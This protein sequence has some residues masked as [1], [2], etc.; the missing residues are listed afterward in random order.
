MISGNHKK[1]ITLLIKSLVTVL[2]LYYIFDQLFLKGK[3]E[4]LWKQFLLV[5]KDSN[6]IYIFGTFFLM[7]LNWAVESAKWQY[8]LRLIEPANFLKSFKAVIAGV[9]ISIFTP[10]RIGEFGGR[11]LF[12]NDNHR[13]KAILLSI[14]GSIS[15]LLITVICGIIGYTIF[16]YGKYQFSLIEKSLLLSIGV[17][18]TCVSLYSYYNFPYLSNV[19]LRLQIL[20]RTRTYL[21]VFHLLSNR[22]LTNL[23]GLSIL[24]YLIFSIQ[25]LILLRVFGI[26]VHPIYGLV[27][28][29]IIFFV[30]A[31]VPT[32]ALTELGVRGAAAMFF[33]S[34]FSNNS[35]GILAASYSLWFINL[36]IPALLGLPFIIQAK[37]FS[38]DTG[39]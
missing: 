33:L 28:I 25:F 39:V 3:F 17:L 7:L 2:C 30:M 5:E 21:K 36:V 29:S 18:S 24:R 16:A 34:P 26:D 15:Q 10:N 38:D 19:L 20:K 8:L 6:T 14:A 4:L 31:V 27:L 13:I 11:I 12:L 22:K 23:L 32:F 37:V 1:I 9:S 35:L